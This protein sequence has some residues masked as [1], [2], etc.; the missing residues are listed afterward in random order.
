MR[1]MEQAAKQL[2][3]KHFGS[4]PAH[5]VGVP[6]TLEVLGSHA[7]A[8][9]GLVI[10]AAFDRRVSVAAGPRQDGRV[11]VVAAGRV[12]AAVFWLDRLKPDGGSDW[13]NVVKAVLA[14][15]RRKRAHFGGLN[16]AMV[17]AI[18][19]GVGAG[20]LESGLLAVALAVR[21]VSPFA[22]TELGADLGPR[23]DGRGRLP[24][25][26]PG[27][28]VLLARWCLEAGR[29]LGG[30]GPQLSRL[31][32]ALRARAWHVAEVDCRLWTLDHA[33]LIGEVLVLCDSGLRPPAGGDG[34]ASLR[35]VW[36][37]AAR[38]LKARSLRSVELGYL[39]ANRSRL[40]ERQHACAY[41]VVGEV[42]R[43]VAAER[44]LREDDHRQVGF[45]MLGSH[46]SGRE[47][48]GHTPAEL[49][50]LVELARRH[51]G[52]LGARMMG[53]GYGGATIN[54]VAYH[55]VV[56]FVEAISRGYEDRTGKPIR[57]LVCQLVEGAG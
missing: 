18:P 15:L 52:C 49:D 41:H 20:S 25:L 27:E 56:G 16:L 29:M 50:L 34:L 2:Y 38:G 48:L 32:V 44:A 28:R 33:P 40:T 54:L 3:R 6:G 47:H 23:R 19:A 45:Y 31:L 55:Q 46:E 26:T 7:E 21:Q 43:V 11:E 30:A 13:V 53:D 12:G 17:D 57:P 51:P 24:P 39:R 35:L 36:G 1:H 5:V 14:V 42:Q 4:V 22:L 10:L 9:E 37:E 8:N